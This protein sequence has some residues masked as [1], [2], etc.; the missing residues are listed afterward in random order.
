M[1]T[2]NAAAPVTLD[3][4]L[5]HKFQTVLITILWSKHI[6]ETTIFEEIMWFTL[7]DFIHIYKYFAQKKKNSLEDVFKIS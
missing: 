1:V 5:I 2:I 4:L 7:L 6:Y 3:K